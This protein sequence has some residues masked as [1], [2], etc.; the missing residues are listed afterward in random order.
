MQPHDAVSGHNRIYG[1]RWTRMNAARIASIRAL[2]I[3][4]DVLIGVRMDR[5]VPR[6]FPA[7]G[8]AL[9]V[10][11]VLVALSVEVVPVKAERQRASIPAMERAPNIAQPIPP[12]QSTSIYSVFLP[13]TLRYD[14]PRAP[15]GIQFYGSLQ[16]TTGF[17]YA[18][19]AKTGWLRLPGV[20]S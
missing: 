16:A 19:A 13:L 2:E 3:Y 5:F 6:V 10:I 8:F 7:I 1:R 18:I 15:F 20:W 12:L 4:R 14:G 9:L 17:T 11:A